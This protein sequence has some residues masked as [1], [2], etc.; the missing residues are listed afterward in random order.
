MKISLDTSKKTYLALQKC[1]K[2][3]RNPQSIIIN[4]FVHV[5]VTHDTQATYM[6]VTQL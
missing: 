1:P 2:N 4:V 6:Q 5:Y 3:L